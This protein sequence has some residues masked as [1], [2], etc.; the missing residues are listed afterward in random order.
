MTEETNIRNVKLFAQ[1]PDAIKS[2]YRLD[3]D[4][5]T[6]EIIVHEPGYINILIDH[7]FSISSDDVTCKIKNSRVCVNLWIKSRIMHVTVY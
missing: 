2:M 7:D 4:Q 1:I 6:S 3:I 5:E